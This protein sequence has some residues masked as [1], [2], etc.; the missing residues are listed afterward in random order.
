MKQSS[1]SNQGEEIIM[2]SQTYD[3]F[4][5]GQLTEGANRNEARQKVASIFKANE[6]KLNKLFSGKQVMIKSGVDDET[7]SKYR[8]AFRKAGALVDIRLSAASSKNKE[9][10]TTET[11]SHKSAEELTLLPPNT[12]SLIDC[13][14]KITPQPIPDISSITLASPGS[15]ID[16]SPDPEPVEIDTS[17]LS[18]APAKS[19][20]L[21]DCNIEKEHYPI[22]DISHLD[23]DR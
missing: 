4:F 17:K 13:A 8:E 16:E 9:K 18:A 7:A 10:P 14:K 12:G 23:I 1:I 5:S 21:E 19:G 2:P 15:V 6:D 20:T 3:I 11:T 22:P